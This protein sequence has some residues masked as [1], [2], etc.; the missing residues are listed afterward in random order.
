MGLGMID[1]IN[2]FKEFKGLLWCIFVSEKIKYNIQSLVEKSPSD[3]FALQVQ[4]FGLIK[5][6]YQISWSGKAAY[7]EWQIIS[8]C[9]VKF[10]YCR[11]SVYFSN[12]MFEWRFCR[13]PPPLDPLGWKRITFVEDSTLRFG[14]TWLLLRKFNII[15]GKTSSLQIFSHFYWL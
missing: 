13:Q 6:T 15:A 1:I 3:H 7:V 8:I 2:S 14:H 10:N 5:P 9:E 4:F 12:T 11:C